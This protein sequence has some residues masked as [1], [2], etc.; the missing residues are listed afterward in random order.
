MDHCASRSNPEAKRGKDNKRLAQTTRAALYWTM[1]ISDGVANAT[2]ATTRRLNK[3]HII[4]PAE[5]SL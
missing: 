4:S 5:V 1:N 3:F 2:R